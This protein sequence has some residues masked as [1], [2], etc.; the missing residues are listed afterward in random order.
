MALLLAAWL[1][2][3]VQPVFAAVPVAA[4]MEHCDHSG[5]CPEMR[6]VACEAD[7]DVN[8]DGQRLAVPPRT[9]FLLALLPPDPLVAARIVHAD[10]DLRPPPTGPPL[11]IRLCQLRN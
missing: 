6:P 3:L 7:N 2:L 1:N 8:T 11:T 9:V 4:G 5:D 10:H